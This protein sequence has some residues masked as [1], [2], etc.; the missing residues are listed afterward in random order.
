MQP[1]SKNEEIVIEES[2]FDLDF[3]RSSEG[4]QQMQYVCDS[5]VKKSLEKIVK[6]CKNCRTKLLNMENTINKFI[7]AKE[8]HLKKC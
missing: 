5:V 2:C 3:N 4:L 1:T 6:N 8:Y 7:S